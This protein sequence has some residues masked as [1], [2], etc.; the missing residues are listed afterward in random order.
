MLE[1]GYGIISTSGR[2]DE[3]A[4]RFEAE[5]D[6]LIQLAETETA[7]RRLGTEIQMNRRRG[8]CAGTDPDPRVK[9]PG[10]VHQECD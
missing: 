9:E 1:R 8:K 3:T 4:E 10:E 6:L 5:L 2:I 7:M